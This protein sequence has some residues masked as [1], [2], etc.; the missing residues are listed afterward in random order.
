MQITGV[1]AARVRPALKAIP[2]IY[3]HFGLLRSAVDRAVALRR[4]L[5][6]LFGADQKIAELQQILF[7]RSI[8]LPAT[9]VPLAERNLLSGTHQ[10][11]CCT[12]DELL[13][14]MVRAF[15]EAKDAV[16]GV[17]RAWGDLAA[18][19]ERTEARMRRLGA[20]ADADRMLEETRGRI[21]A[22]PLGA[23]EYLKSHVGPVI[24]AAEG[25]VAASQLVEQ[26]LREA[27]GRWSSL[28]QLHG[29]S[30][31]AA[32]ECAVRFADGGGGQPVPDEKLE[33][34]RLWLERLEARRADG[35]PAALNVG[36]RNWCATAEAYARQDEAVC[37][38]VS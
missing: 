9:D 1:T 11:E 6:A 27:W 31:A 19:L 22:D 16:V 32:A 37:A 21:Q 36:L 24:A 10:Q 23:L 7:G 8:Y 26:A 15:T 5:P 3:V 4:T 12:A 13:G 34:L 17:G 14:R 30:V 38:G 18:E 28:V 20:N 25:K 33:A 35:V 2:T 29:E